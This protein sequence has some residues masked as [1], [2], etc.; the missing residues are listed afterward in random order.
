MSWAEK[1]L[2][3]PGTVTFQKGH[4]SESQGQAL[5]TTDLKCHYKIS[6]E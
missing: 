2:L 1:G 5:T 4:Y 3:I 6:H